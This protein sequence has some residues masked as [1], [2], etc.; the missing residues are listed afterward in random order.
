MQLFETGDLVLIAQFF[1]IFYTYFIII[2]HMFTR[3]LTYCTLKSPTEVFMNIMG[4]EKKWRKR[5]K[6]NMLINN[7]SYRSVVQYCGFNQMQF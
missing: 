4:R 7:G 3:L 5:E 2:S 6:N 1:V